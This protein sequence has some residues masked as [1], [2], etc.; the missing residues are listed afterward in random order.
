MLGQLGVGQSLSPEEVQQALRVYNRMAGKWSVQ[1]LLQYWINTRQ[2]LLTGGQQNYQVGPTA[3]PPGFSGLRPVWVET[4]N[5]VIPFTLEEK[6]QNM[7]SKSQ[8]NAIRDKGA[9]TSAA[10]APQDC[11]PEMGFPNITLHFWPIPQQSVTINLGVWELIQQFATIFDVVNLP[12]AY[13]NAIVTN[14]SFEL[15]AYYDVPAE[16]ITSVQQLAADALNE[17]KQLNARTIEGALGESETLQDPTTGNPP[18]PP[19]Q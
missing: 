19:A 18:P 8:W 10:G 3:T 16:T 9:M 1:R 4:C 15:C 11:W 5:C 2:Y 6:T 17:V 13:E 12:P 7:L 14:L